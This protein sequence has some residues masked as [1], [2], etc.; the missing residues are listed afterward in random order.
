M[1]LAIEARLLDRI[2]R[3]RD[4]LAILIGLLLAS[5]LLAPGAR[6]AR[7]EPDIFGSRTLHSSSLKMFPKWR[8]AMDR[9]QKELGGCPAATC[10]TKS[11]QAM[12]E[13]L[14]GVDL[15]TQVKKVNSTLNKHPYI[16]DPINWNLPDYWATPFQFLRKNGD[17]EDYAISKFMALRALGVPS[18]LM[19]IVV[20]NDLNLGLAHAILVVTVD[21]TPF[22]LD[23]QIKTVVPA[24]S[25]HHYQPVYGVND[26]GWWLYRAG[27]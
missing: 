8:G 3:W 18:D 2:W 26:K 19:R 14:K 11:W 5:L 7:F 9:F 24:S 1:R 12:L 22:V 23:N 10:N 16:I 6:A 21:G 17:C 13:G 15:K 4:L 25:I 27:S 20:L